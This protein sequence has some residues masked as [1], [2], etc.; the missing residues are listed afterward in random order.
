VNEIHIWL[1][2]HQLNNTSALLQPVGHAC[3][4]AAQ[5]Q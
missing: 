4:I 2:L 3:C 1:L 5:A